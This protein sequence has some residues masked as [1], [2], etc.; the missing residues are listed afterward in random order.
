MLGSNWQNKVEHHG[1]QK[2]FDIEGPLIA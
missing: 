1:I 2:G